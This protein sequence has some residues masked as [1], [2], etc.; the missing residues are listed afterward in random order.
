MLIMP[1]TDVN[2]QAL[3]ENITNDFFANGTPL[4]DG[5]VKTAKEHSFTPEEVTRLV[6]KTNTA[7]SLHLLKTAS[8]KKSTFTLAQL[9]LVLQQTHPSESGV[10]K[11]ASVYT[12][13]PDTRTK[14][15]NTFTKTASVKK[16][17]QEEDDISASQAMFVVR[18]TLEERKLQKMAT[19][20]TVQDKI[21][22]LASEFNVWNGP[23][24]EKFASDCM[25]VFGKKSIPVLEGLAK[26]LNAPLNKT[27]SD[28]GSCAYIDDRTDHMKAMRTICDGLGSIIKIGSEISQLEYVLQTLWAGLKKAAV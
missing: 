6:E 10:E 16:K 13:I 15:N 4:S 12:G 22:Y 14:K 1:T 20:M 11:T 5:I 27:A 19:E 25:H 9:E 24:F 17:A 26:Y 18:K 23:S 8:D 21:D 28:Y 3:A 7:A 2:F